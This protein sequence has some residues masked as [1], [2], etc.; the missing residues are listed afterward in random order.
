MLCERGAVERPH[1]PG[2][3]HEG[4]SMPLRVRTSN[5]AS[6]RREAHKLPDAVC[7]SFPFAT[8]PAE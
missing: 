5:A 7:A 3:Q 8:M 1:E 6:D 2:T 4:T